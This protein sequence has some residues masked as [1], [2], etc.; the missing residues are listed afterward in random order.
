[1]K[2][3]LNILLIGLLTLLFTA[4]SNDHNTVEK[5]EE[6]TPL[7][8]SAAIS[9]TDALTEIKTLYEE[10][11]PVD[12]SFNLGGSGS[13][14]QQIQQG[15]PVDVF[16]SA[17]INWMDTLEQEG[18]LHEKT[19]IKVVENQLVLISNKENQ[20]VAL[21]LE[22][23][24][25]D[26]NEQI[27]IG[28][29]E[30]VPAGNYTEEALRNIGLW[31]TLQDRIIL[32]KDVRQV[33]TYVETG[34]VTYGFVYESDAINSKDSTIL[35]TISSDLHQAITYPGAILKATKHPKEAESFLA[36]LSSKEAR[37]I[38]EKYGFQL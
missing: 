13:L 33:L 8:I 36:F 15:A 18:L 25:N 9:L 1:M 4:C 28:N 11:H 21:P 17:N 34:N 29:P 24:F 19:R 22:E 23:Q 6:R 38:F 7:T 2:N 32:A 14:A 37:E 20:S 3:L 35:T 31:D 12:L 26:P 5:P 10:D 27:A 30:S 16:I